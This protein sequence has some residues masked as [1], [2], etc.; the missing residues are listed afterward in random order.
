MCAQ[1]FEKNLR[2]SKSSFVSDFPSVLTSEENLRH[3]SFHHVIEYLLLDRKS[4]SSVKQQTIQCVFF[5]IE[6]DKSRNT[7]TNSIT[8]KKKNRSYCNSCRL[9]QRRKE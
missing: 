5:F 6:I 7:V 3:L 9:S 1:Y 8:I 2:C 4:K